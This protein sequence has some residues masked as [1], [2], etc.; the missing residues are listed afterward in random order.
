MAFLVILF[1][2]LAFRMFRGCLKVA[3]LGLIIAWLLHHSPTLPSIS[4]T[5]LIRSPGKASEFINEP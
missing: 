3:L 2:G 4:G 5:W 1:F